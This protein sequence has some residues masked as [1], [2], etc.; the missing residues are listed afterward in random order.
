MLQGY[1]RR[2][3]KVYLGSNE[4]GEIDDVGERDLTVRR[5]TIRK[6]VVRLPV[7]VVAEADEGIVD[8]HDDHRT[9]ALLDL[10]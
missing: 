9:R 8:L 1:V 6:S 7:E 3:W 2:G 5:G 10:E 4:I